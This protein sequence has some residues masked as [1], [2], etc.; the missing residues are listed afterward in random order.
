MRVVIQRVSE[1][2]VTINDVLKSSVQQGLLV[3]AGF[4][5]DDSEEDL[6]WTC[7]KIIQ[8]RIFGDYKEIGR[9]HV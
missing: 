3:L 2:S 9:A 6:N 1:A 5:T 8:L 7:N 4:V